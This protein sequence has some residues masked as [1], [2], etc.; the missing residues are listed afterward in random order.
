MTTVTDTVLVHVAAG[1]ASVVLNRPDKLNAITPM[2]DHR[3]AAVLNELAQ[4]PD[5]RAVILGGAGGRAFSAGA[6][7]ADTSFPEGFRIGSDW[8]PSLGGRAGQALSDF[9]KPVVAAIHGYCLGGAAEL[10][11]H[12]DFRIASEDAVIAF[13]E[14]DL[15]MTPG[16]GGSQLLP[17]IAGRAV[18]LDLLMTGRRIDGSE[19]ARL[20]VIHRAVARDELQTAARTLATQLAGKPST[21][22]RLVK[23]AVTM[24]DRLS[25]ADGLRLER[26]L[27]AYRFATTEGNQTQ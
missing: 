16:W 21:A 18:A 25:I 23:R 3:L 4:Q 9:P 10:V 26:D 15:G 6:D 11:L 17:R 13:P 7:M 1:V 5:C 2:M 20:G 27:V 22:I 12:A 8:N 19:A 24:S 14:V